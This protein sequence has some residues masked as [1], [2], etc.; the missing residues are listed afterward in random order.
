MDKTLKLPPIRLFPI[1]PGSETVDQA[2]KV[3]EEACELLAATKEYRR[4]S[5]GENFDHMLEEAMD[6]YQA[7]GEFIADEP[8]VVIHAAYNL[9]VEKNRL[10]GRYEIHE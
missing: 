6:V 7:L 2:L 9:V 3:V 1:N 8:D 4:N 10:R 5:S